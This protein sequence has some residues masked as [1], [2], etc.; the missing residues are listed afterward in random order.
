M[1]VVN[2]VSHS[3]KTANI[4]FHMTQFHSLLERLLKVLVLVVVCR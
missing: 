3:H 1:N 4:I 2:D